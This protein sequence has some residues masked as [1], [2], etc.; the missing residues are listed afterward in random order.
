[1]V[2]REGIDDGDG[3]NGG[4]DDSGD[5]GGDG[6]GGG[7]EADEVP[8]RG[9]SE[10]NEHTSFYI[11]FELSNNFNGKRWKLRA[12]DGRQGGHTMQ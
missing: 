8:R 11:F 5:G 3:D 7:V 9:R 4:N 10:K 6:D 2:G 12:G 1:M